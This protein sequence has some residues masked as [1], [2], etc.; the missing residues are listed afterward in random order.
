MTYGNNALKSKLDNLSRVLNRVL[1]LSSSHV[2][3]NLKSEHTSIRSE[4]E[5]KQRSVA[6]IVVLNREISPQQ[7]STLI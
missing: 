1:S 7:S 5:V 2:N 4:V 3:K 6:G